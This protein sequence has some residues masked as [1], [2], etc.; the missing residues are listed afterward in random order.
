MPL[1]AFTIKE[2]VNATDSDI[3]ITIASL[4]HP[5]E[6]LGEHLVIPHHQSITLFLSFG[7]QEEAGWVPPSGYSISN[8]SGASPFKTVR[9]IFELV[10]DPLLTIP[11]V[12]EYRFKSLPHLYSWSLYCDEKKIGTFS[13]A[14]N[15][16]VSY[17]LIIKDN[18]MIDVKLL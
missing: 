7:R 11:V 8:K 5:I 3:A 1:A 15:K 18:C 9:C 13:G 16:R 14:E 6:Q 2:L 12:H 10:E 17:K 4:G